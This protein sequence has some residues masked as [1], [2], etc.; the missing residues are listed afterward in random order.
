MENTQFLI[1]KRMLGKGAEGEILLAKNVIN[2]QLC[3]VKVLDKTNQRILRK[4]KR[5]YTELKIFSRIQKRRFIKNDDTEDEED[6]IQIETLHPN[7]IR[8]FHAEENNMSVRLYLEY[9]EYGS[10]S[11]FL[12][13][14]INLSKSI[15]M[16][17]F[18]NVLDAV[19][20]LHDVVNICHRDIKL[21]NILVS[22]NFVA[23]LCDF[24]FSTDL[25]NDEYL[26]KK[27]GTINS[28][29][30]EII[31]KKP[32]QGRKADSWSLGVVFYF[33]FYN[34]YPYTGIG[35]DQLESNVL[36]K[37]LRIPVRATA[38]EYFILRSLLRKNPS[39]RLT[40][41]QLKLHLAKGEFCNIKQQ[42]DDIPSTS[43]ENEFTVE[44][45]TQQQSIF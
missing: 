6:I 19:C 7:I 11:D 9:C 29:A 31:C 40:P 38:V 14:N 2:N 36:G 18:L 15:K 4:P 23:K 34:I 32:Y 8:L 43:S 1:S 28:M 5:A 26:H 30:P 37:P 12:R 3:A 42:S 10:L 27:C 41:S 16:K 24:G 45:T 13:K 44:K 17:M 35:N 33:L 25:R 39:S 20:F 22:K 21:K